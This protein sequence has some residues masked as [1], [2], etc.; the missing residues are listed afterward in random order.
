MAEVRFDLSDFDF[1]PVVEIKKIRSSLHPIMTGN[2]AYSDLLSVMK[3]EKEKFRKKQRRSWRKQA[4]KS[5]HRC[6]N[7]L[8]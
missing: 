5:Y 7:D 4:K 2:D 6:K 8:N 3:A 1:V